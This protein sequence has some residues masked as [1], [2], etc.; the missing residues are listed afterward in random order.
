M[1]VRK[2]RD[3]KIYDHSKNY[4]LNLQNFAWFRTSVGICYSPFFGL[5]L[6]SVNFLKLQSYNFVVLKVHYVVIQCRH[7]T[8]AQSYKLIN[9]PIVE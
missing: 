5:S 7:A 3:A 9:K 4:R 6:T 2:Q 1:T 8:H